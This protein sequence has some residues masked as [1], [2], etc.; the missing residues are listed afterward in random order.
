MFFHHV[1]YHWPT[2]GWAALTL[3]PCCE[4]L[5]GWNKM[6]GYSRM[7][8][9]IWCLMQLTLQIDAL[10]S[11]TSPFQ[12]VLLLEAGNL[13][14]TFQQKSLQVGFMKPS[15]CKNMYFSKMQ[16]LKVSILRQR[17]YFCHFSY[18]HW[19]ILVFLRY[20]QQRYQR[21]VPKFRG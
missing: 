5:P 7:T 13:D 9:I 3:S 11:I 18:F 15:F 20:L 21:S 10:N 8:L 12:Q 2:F 14:N 4:L 6:G 1:T 16:K 19:Q 17:L